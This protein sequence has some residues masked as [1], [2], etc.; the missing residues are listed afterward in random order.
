MKENSNFETKPLIFELN[1]LNADNAH[2]FKLM[3]TFKHLF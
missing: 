1:S 3:Q 2:L